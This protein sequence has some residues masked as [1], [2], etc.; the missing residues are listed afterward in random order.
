MRR[1]GLAGGAAYFFETFAFAALAQ[2]AGL[3]GATALAAYTMLHNI[4]ATVFMI[5]LGLS[6]ATAVRVGQAVGARRP[7]TR[8]GSSGSPASPPR[9]G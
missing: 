3:L 2:A 1:I 9:W 4:E 7:R 5:A 6:V 8:R